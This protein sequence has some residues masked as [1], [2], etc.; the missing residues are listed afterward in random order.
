MKRST[1]FSTAAVLTL[2]T[3]PGVVT[4]FAFNDPNKNSK[5][6]IGENPSAG[7]IIFHDANGNGLLDS[8]V[9]RSVTVSSAVRNAPSP[10]DP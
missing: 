8:G 1:L 3:N 6:D 7:L 2:S 5:P 9:D 4:G 10:R